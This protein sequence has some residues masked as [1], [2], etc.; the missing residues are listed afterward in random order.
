MRT[1]NHF[2]NN[3][4]FINKVFIKFEISEIF[5]FFDSGPKILGPVK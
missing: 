4:S 5:F 3:L 2:L 1:E